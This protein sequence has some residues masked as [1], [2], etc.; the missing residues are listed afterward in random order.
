MLNP[1]KQVLE[2][3][4]TVC[5]T[6][7]MTRPEGD[8]VLP[9]ITYAMVTDV[10]IGPF[11]DRIEFQVDCYTD[12]FADCLALARNADSVMTGLGYHRTY[13]TPDSQVRRSESL[14]QITMSYAARVDML[15]SR[16][17]GGF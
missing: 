6:V 8:V 12:D 17:T 4:E 11:E 1:R 10:N 9:L 7:K 5:R 16:I 2:Q 14:F 3:L 13:V 15:H